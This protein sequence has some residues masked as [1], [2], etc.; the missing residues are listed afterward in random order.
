MNAGK[1][2]A[3]EPQRVREAYRRWRTENVVISDYLAGE[4]QNFF[5]W[6]N[7]EGK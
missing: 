6:L 5:A 4:Q 3:F 2:E 7:E 1:G